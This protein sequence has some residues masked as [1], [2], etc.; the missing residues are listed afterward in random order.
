MIFSKYILQVVFHLK[1]IYYGLLYIKTCLTNTN[2]TSK[3]LK[4]AKNVNFWKNAFFCP[5]NAF[6][7]KNGN[8]NPCT[9]QHRA[10]VKE[11]FFREVILHQFLK[12]KNRALLSKNVQ[13]ILTLLNLAQKVPFLEDLK[14]KFPKVTGTKDIICMLPKHIIIH[15][16][17]PPLVKKILWFW[18][19]TIIF[20]F[21][22]IHIFGCFK[23]FGGQIE[24]PS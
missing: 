10:N 15:R 17:R 5:K 14:K 6:F 3:P 13:A 23:G 22:K 9:A 12:R 8:L 20:H 18:P 16:F 4:T 24:I 1:G 11:L 19:K 2:L 21:P 7:E